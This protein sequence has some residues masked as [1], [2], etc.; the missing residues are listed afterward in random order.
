MKSFL[1]RHQP[2]APPIRWLLA[3]LGALIAIGVIGALTTYSDAVFLMAPFGAGCVLLFSVPSS[4]LSQPMNVV[5][6][7]C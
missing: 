3:G 1:T 6:G 5:G 4:P 2:K 7:I